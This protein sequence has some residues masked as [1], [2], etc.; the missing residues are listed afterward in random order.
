MIYFLPHKIKLQKLEQKLTRLS[1]TKK[2]QSKEFY[3]Y[4]ARKIKN[5]FK[6]YN[7]DPN[8]KHF[9]I[10]FV[11]E[12]GDLCDTSLVYELVNELKRKVSRRV[13]EDSDSL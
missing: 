5:Q 8:F 11:K 10:T 12:M 2:S 9:M 3:K 1:L 6:D 4:Q 7:K 13:T